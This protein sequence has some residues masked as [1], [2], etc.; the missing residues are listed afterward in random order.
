M[1]Y[2]KVQG[3]GFEPRITGEKYEVSHVDIKVKKQVVI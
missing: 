1:K 2:K 3:E